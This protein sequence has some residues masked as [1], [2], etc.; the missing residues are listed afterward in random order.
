MNGSI[1]P[2]R[3]EDMIQITEDYID[4]ADF[5]EGMSAEDI[6]TNEFIDESISYDH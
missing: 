2:E 5:P 4:G 6:F 1:D 3:I